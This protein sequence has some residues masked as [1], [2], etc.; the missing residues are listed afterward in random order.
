MIFKKEYLNH[1]QVIEEPGTYIVKVGNTVKPEYF[2]E[3]GSKSRFIVNLRAASLENLKRCID[4]MGERTKC[5]FDEIKDCFT[6]GVLWHEDI[7]DMSKLPTKG[8]SIIATYDYVDDVFRCIS[9]TL[10]PRKS[11]QTFDLNAYNKTRKLFN[12]LLTYE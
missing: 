9:L 11:L 3:D 7:N 10:I 4:I 1:Y 6:S 2:I 8:E 5:D 12:E